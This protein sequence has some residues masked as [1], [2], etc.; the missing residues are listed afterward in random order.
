MIEGGSVR[1]SLYHFFLQYYLIISHTNRFITATTKLILPLSNHQKDFGNCNIYEVTHQNCSDSLSKHN[2]L[3]M[4]NLLWLFLN[5]A[6][7]TFG[8]PF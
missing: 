6:N 2:S 1:T 4:Q 7:E 5:V 8:L 3:K